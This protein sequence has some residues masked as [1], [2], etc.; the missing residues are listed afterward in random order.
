MNLIIQGL[1]IHNNDLRN[2]AKLSSASSIERITGQAFRLVGANQQQDISEYCADAQLDFAF[3][4]QDMPLTY[5]GLF[6]TDMDSTLLAIE[7]I[8]EIADMCNVKPQVSEITLSTMKGDIGFA[9]SLTRRTQLLQ[10]LHQDALQRV[11]DERLQL[12]PGAEEM[13][14]KLKAAGLKT[15]V[16]SG[17]FTFFTDRIKVQL[18]LDYAIANTLEIEDEKLTGKVA[19]EIIGAQGKAEALKQIRNKLGLKREQVIAVGDGANDLDMLAE[20]GISI[21]Y[22]AKP[23][24]QQQATYSINHVGLDGIINL[25]R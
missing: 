15:M 9:E 23:I 24:V 6:A 17:G 2:L 4:A 12:S 16:I 18:E 3:I 22:H 25:F 7:S 14:Q 10:G 13:L 21:A 20:A 8:D 11:Y 19:G 5:F 1:D